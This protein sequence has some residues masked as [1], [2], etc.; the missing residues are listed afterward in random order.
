MKHKTHKLFSSLLLLAL[1][2]FSACKNKN[3]DIDS[4]KIERERI[5]PAATN[6]TITGSYS[7]TG[8]VYGMKINIGEKENLIDASIYEMQLEGMD[9]SVIVEGLKPNTEYYYR[10]T[11]NFGSNNVLQT[12]TNS[13]NTL[14]EP[15]MVQTLEVLS[16]DDTTYRV[17]CEVVS[18]GGFQTT[19][20]GICWNTYGDPNLGDNHLKH[21]ENGLGEYTCIMS[22]L[23][24]NTT[25]YVRAYAKN[26]EVDVCFGNVIDFVTPEKPIDSLRIEVYSSPEE[27]GEVLGGGIFAYGQTCTVRAI[28]NTGFNFVNWTENG[29]HLTNEAEYRF[30]VTNNRILTACFTTQAFVV[31]AEADPVEGGR[32]E[33]AGGFDFGN[34]CTLTAEANPGYE[35]KNWTK[36]NAVVSTNNPFTFR[37]FE[38]SNYK[39]HFQAKNYSI[40]VS[41]LPN[42]CGTVIKDPDQTSYLYNDQ[43]ILLATPAEGYQFDHWQ[44]NNNTNPMRV[45][46]VTDDA[47]YTACFVEAPVYTYTI[48]T[49]V[50][51]DGSGYVNGG[52]EYSQGAIC[53]L[54]AYAYN[55]YVFVNWLKNGTIIEGGASITFEVTENATYEAYF[56]YTIGVPTGAINGLFSIN[57]NHDQVYFSQGNLQYNATQGT[58]AIATG[59]TAQG[60]WRFAENQWDYIG[61]SNANISS[62]Y[63]GWID[64]F[65]WGTSGWNN[66]NVFYHPWDSQNNEIASQGYGYG[67]ASGS[68]YLNDLT[69]PYSNADWGVYNA[70]SNGGD[71]CNHWRI[72]TQ[73]EWNYVINLREGDRFVKAQIINGGETIKG[74]ILLPDDWDESTYDLSFINLGNAGFDTN[75]ITS[76]N[77][78]IL[79]RAGAVFL[80][81]AGYRVGSE[82]RDAGNAGYYWSA[83]CYNSGIANNIDFGL[84]YFMSDRYYRYGGQSVRLVCPAR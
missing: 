32:V 70:I 13:F 71:K 61:S 29:I 84:A 81:V 18:D 15:L 47:S 62:T 28:A 48:T 17:K 12:E 23:T 34:E 26:S 10:Y 7:F 77:W 74:V 19:E 5:V 64:L 46:T 80:P 35:F 21:D 1:I 73:S 25:Y 78:N 75:S 56:I 50:I 9:F 63:N 8:D 24:P 39:A 54:E 20:R 60:T 44:D 69:G 79:E 68:Y 27:G 65:G 37:V 83:S 42:G 2:G 43:V 4:F 11:I 33:G 30:L 51:P 49:G 53:R 45:I 55:D 67:P 82:I 22:S 72:L 16:I 58:H 52:G 40:N 3:L 57:P 6:V 36:D 76:S 31:S 66:G 38:S 59:G 41:A 14:R